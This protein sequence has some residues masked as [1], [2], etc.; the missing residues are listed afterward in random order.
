MKFSVFQVSRKGG[1]EKNE[2]RMGYCYTREAALFML[3]DGMGGHPE[4][5]VA[6][7]AAVQTAAD[8]FQFEARP[9]VGEVAGFLTSALY[10]A[11][12]RLLHYAASRRMFDTPR[13]TLVLALVQD[14]QL[15]WLH[16][17]DSRLYVVREGTLLTRT[18]DHSYAEQN[19]AVDPLRT[20]PVNRNVLYT[21]IGSPSRP[22]YDLGGPMTLLP[23]D[24]LMLCSDGLWD[25]L[26]DEEIVAGLT[27]APVAQSAPDLVDRAL[28]NGGA[29][30]DN[31]T[32][33]AMDW[34]RGAA[35]D[36]GTVL[37]D[38]MPISGF[39][40]TPTVA[41]PEPH[42]EAGDDSI[43]QSIEQ[44]DEAIRRATGKKD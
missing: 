7:Q 14:G 8:L 27:S 41:L 15:H 32:V 39:M 26:G 5:E 9:R 37:T 29:R 22:V 31:V 18:R 13:T 2:D 28:R 34:D 40:S 30:C 23:G 4:G 44:I 42:D 11:H 12:Q 6:A 17:G 38:V 24:K 36:A 16:C 10:T 20:I 33:V 25:N 1:R 3:A 35:D 19:L 21:C 43:E